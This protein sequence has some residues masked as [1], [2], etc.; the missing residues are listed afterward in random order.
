[1]KTICC[2]CGVLLQD[3]PPEPLSHGYCVP[4]VNKLRAEAGLPLVPENDA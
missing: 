1:M 3:G 4:C 2:E